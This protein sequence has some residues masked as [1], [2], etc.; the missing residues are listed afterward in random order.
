[1]RR[2]GWGAGKERI[3]ATESPKRIMSPIEAR[4]EKT[5]IE[6]VRFI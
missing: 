3:G 6:E 5:S 4:G 1:M 2:R